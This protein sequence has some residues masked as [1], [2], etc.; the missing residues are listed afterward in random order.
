MQT[1]LSYF[2]LTKIVEF[3]PFNLI[4]N[5]TEVKGLSWHYLVCTLSFPESK[6]YT[7][8]KG[9]CLW[10][11]KNFSLRIQK[12]EDGFEIFFFKKRQI[13][14]CFVCVWLCFCWLHYVEFKDRLH[15]WLKGA[16]GQT[17]KTDLKLAMPCRK[18]LLGF[19]MSS[20]LHDNN[21]WHNSVA[22]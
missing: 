8:P 9:L 1:T 22:L 17:Q 11:I 3:T 19:E 6:C 18:K 7:W 2:S 15:V 12:H 13:T 21:F 4:S 16:L 5:A 20:L 10:G 14:H